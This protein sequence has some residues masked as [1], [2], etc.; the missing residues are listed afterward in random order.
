MAYF[1][2]NY[3]WIYNATER[4]WLPFELWPAQ[5]YVL[6]ELLTRREIAA[7]K[8]RQALGLT[9]LVLCYCLW[10]MLFHPA[11]GHPALQQ[12]RR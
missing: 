2:H 4:R 1:I 5:V 8:A 3:C 7:L 12:A 6:G 10:L 11:A 9:W